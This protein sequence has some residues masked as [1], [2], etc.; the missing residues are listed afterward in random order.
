MLER[1]KRWLRQEDDVSKV[2]MLTDVTSARTD[3]LCGRAYWY[4]TLEG[5]RGIVPKSEVIAQRVLQETFTDLRTLT[6]LSEADLSADN[7]EVAVNEILG[8]LSPEDKR[9]R[10]SMELLYRRLGWLVAFALYQEP[11]LRRAY[12]TIPI[13]PEI[14][15]SHDSLRVK[16]ETGRVLRYRNCKEV[17]YRSYIPTSFISARWRGQWQKSAQPHI[18]MKAVE[19]AIGKKVDAMQ[20]MGLAKG[21]YS[22][23][24][25]MGLSHPYVLGHYHAATK[26]W[27]H[28][29]M[30]GKGD[31]WVER[32]IWEYE[33]GLVNWVLKCGREVADAQ[34]PLTT[35]I[36]YKQEVLDAWL[37]HRVHRERAI[38]GMTADCHA[39]LHLRNVHFPQNTLSCTPLFGEPCPYDWLCWTMKPGANPFGAGFV[40]N[41]LSLSTGVIPADDDMPEEYLEG[42]VIA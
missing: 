1:F 30:I 11:Y 37:A 2:I 25:N 18:E 7:M 22:R 24:G 21:F 23:P 32:P 15:L 34:F 42:E 20:V 6:T 35:R 26:E 14:L 28:N 19:E 9:D 4:S 40:P 41:P 27:S 29:Y 8:M 17:V 39:N 3:D 12:E 31:G 13:A 5:G 16:V 10:A 33:E 38:L 36:T